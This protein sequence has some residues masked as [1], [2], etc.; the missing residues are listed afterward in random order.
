MPSV[1]FVM[2]GGFLGAGKTTLISRLAR[3]YQRLGRRVALVTNDQAQHLVDTSRLRAQGF[4]VQEVAGACFCCRFDDLIARVEE[5]ESSERPDVILAEPVGSCTDL[6]AT[7]I[8]PLKRLFPDRFVVA[9]YAVMFKPSVGLPLLQ[10]EVNSQSGPSY[11]FHKQ[12]EEAD[13]IVINRIDEMSASDRESARHVVASRYPGVPIVSLSART[14]EGFESLI[15]L[16]ETA[17]RFGR[18]ILDIDYDIYAEG[19]AALAWLNATVNLKADAP[20]PV[21]DV[22]MAL[23]DRLRASLVADGADI[24]H[25]K[26]S[27]QASQTE[28]VVSVVGSARAAELAMSSGGSSARLAL[29]VNA[30]VVV[31]PEELE[32]HV[33]RAIEWTC[34]EWGATADVETLERFRPGRPMPTHRIAKAELTAT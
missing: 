25:L 13:T 34:G 30:R 21:D 32:A 29:I 23:A 1:S 8:Q 19:E 17:G 3:H 24:A 31:S 11:I 2:L 5:L 27:G 18:R 26:V 22:L 7:V 16:F 12:L 33:R 4:A 15:A 28:S 14:G 6:V 10:D 9:P 20:L